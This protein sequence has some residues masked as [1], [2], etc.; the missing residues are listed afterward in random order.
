M[1]KFKI[2]LKHDKGTVIVT[3]HAMSEDYAIQQICNIEGCPK[4]AIIYV[5]EIVG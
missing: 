2:K 4:E 5:R 3:I 1:R